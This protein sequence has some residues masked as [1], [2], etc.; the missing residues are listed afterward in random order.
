MNKNVPLLLALLWLSLAGHAQKQQTRQTGWSPDDIVKQERINHMAYSPDAGMVV[1]EKKRPSKE[2]DKLV[3]DLYLTR[4]AT[5]KDGQYTSTQLTRSEENDHSPIFSANGELIYFLSSRGSG[6]KIWAMHVL[7]GEAYALDSFATSIS[8]L[9]RL[10]DHS[11]IF[12]AEEGKTLYEQLLEKK[13]DDVMVIE[14]TAHF[15]AS[16]IFAYDLNKKQARRLTDNKHPVNEYAISK[17]GNWLVSSHVGSPHYGVDGQPKN[18]V[19]LWNLESGEKKEILGADYQTPGSFAFTADSKGFYFSSVQSSNPEWNGAGIDL[20]HY[21]DLAT[22][23]PR[24]VELQWDWGLGGNFTVVGN[25]VLAILANGPLNKLAYYQKKGSSW[26]YQAVEAKGME[27]H[28]TPAVVADNREDILFVHSTSS[29]PTQYLKGKLATKRKIATITPEAPLAKLNN[30]L[31]NKKIG[32]SEVMRW[33]G[34]LDEEVNGILYYPYNYEQGRAYPLVL[35]IHGGPSGV[36]QDQ[37]EASWAYYPHLLAEKGA[38]VLMPNYHGSS[39]HGQKFVESIKGHYYE[40]ELTDILNGAQALIDAGKVNKDSMGVMGW[41][42]GA[43]LTTMLTVQ[44]PDLFKVAAPGAGDVNWTSDY[45]TCEFGVTFDQSY[46]GGA[47]WDNLNGKN[48]NENYVLKSPLFEMEKVKTPTI[49]FHGSEDRAVPRDQGWEYYRSLQQLKQA[50]VRFLWF[51]GQPHGL[52]KL[53]HQKRKIEEEVA[54][55]DRYLFGKYKAPNESFSE[56]SPL[57]MLLEKEKSARH[58]NLLGIWKEGLLLPEVA[59]VK[60][61]SLHIGLYEI[62]NAQFKAYK[63]AHAFAAGQD[64]YPAQNVSFEDARAYTNWLS[65]KTGQR[66][67]LPNSKEAAEL[68]KKAREAGTDENTLN[69]WAGYSITLDELPAFRQKLQEVKGSLVKEAGTFKPLA[70]GDA[71]VFDLGGNVA[72]FYEEGGKC[73]V[74]GYSAYDFVDPASQECSSAP[75]HTGFRVV[76]D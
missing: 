20:L 71:K 40:L 33:K 48:Y 36:D 7:G 25:D 66:Y 51:P 52:Q 43:I 49:I 42:N 31:D 19:Y 32:R 76:R 39:N 2:K 59:A 22:S 61:D 60:K 64:N 3:S 1:W 13:K 45:G 68:Q 35:A 21:F 23:Q 12:V 50:P 41:S 14:D 24:Q 15:K 37:W 11:L 4:L 38:F 62:T 57:A 30:H 29:T 44:H 10:G 34:A 18:K 72:E 6:K 73:A 74:Y 63:P 16:R 65:E 8:S 5:L 17:D 67:R 9:Q 47:P 69:Y 46:F 26:T 28:L 70:L 27:Q 58:Q 55:F 56:E 54:W 75:E 53:S